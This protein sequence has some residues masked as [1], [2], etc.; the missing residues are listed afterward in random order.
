[1]RKYCLFGSS[2]I[3]TKS[4]EE[5]SN[6]NSI[7]EVFRA[8]SSSWDPVK[9]FEK[10]IDRNNLRDIAR[11]SFLLKVISSVLPGIAPTDSKKINSIIDPNTLRIYHLI[12]IFIDQSIKIEVLKSLNTG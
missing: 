7:N 11:I 6:D 8:S 2:R 4:N 5:H 3:P 10:L 9:L 12:E 1:M